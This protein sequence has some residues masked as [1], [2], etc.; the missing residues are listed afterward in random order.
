MILFSRIKSSTSD[1]CSV[2]TESGREELIEIEEVGLAISR[3]S[4]LMSLDPPRIGVS[5]SSEVS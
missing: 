5:N 2:L 1:A 4:L 3:L